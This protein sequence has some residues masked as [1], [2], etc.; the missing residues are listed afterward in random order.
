MTDFEVDQIW[1]HIRSEHKE[2]ADFATLHTHER[3]FDYVQDLL[4]VYYW[5][6]IKVLE[7]RPSTFEGL[8]KTMNDLIDLHHHLEP[9]YGCGTPV[10]QKYG[11]RYF[12]P[13]ESIG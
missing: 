9:K 10:R 5:E 4:F 12:C 11:S 3:S 13:E 2:R 7:K 1:F 8:K 6:D